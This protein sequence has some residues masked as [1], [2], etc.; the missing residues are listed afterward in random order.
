MVGGTKFHRRVIPGEISRVLVLNSLGRNL[1]CCRTAQENYALTETSLLSRGTLGLCGPPAT[2]AVRGRGRPR[3]ISIFNTR[4]RRCSAPQVPESLTRRNVLL[5]LLFQQLERERS[6][7]E[8]HVVKVADI[9]LRSQA[10]LGFLA[11]LD[12]LELAHLVGESL[13]RP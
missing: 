2:H 10:L 12:D 1:R 7:A 9:E 3:H 8:H 5:Y 13:G 6:V 4:T 11:K